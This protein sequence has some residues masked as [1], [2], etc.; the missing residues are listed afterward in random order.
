MK[1]VLRL[2]S[3]IP[4]LRGVDWGENIIEGARRELL[5]IMGDKWEQAEVK[6][7]F[8]TDIRVVD[9]NAAITQG[10]VSTR[11]VDRDGDVMVPSGAMLEDFTKSPITL[12]NH[13]FS[14]VL[15]VE[16][17]LVVDDVGLWSKTQ[18]AP[19]ETVADPYLLTIRNMIVKGIIRARSIA[20]IPIEVLTPMF[21]AQRFAD[22]VKELEGM[23]KQKLSGVF[24]VVNKWL[25]TEISFVPV[26]ANQEALHEA[27][28]KGWLT[29]KTVMKQLGMKFV[30]DGSP[31][32]PSKHIRKVAPQRIIKRVQLSTERNTQPTSSGDHDITSEVVREIRRLRGQL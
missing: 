27:V 24:A 32:R 18:L 1:Q 30:I 21:D 19:A 17:E 11:A 6:R 9:P 3:L 26:G 29:D 25:L 31:K 2:C 23:W 15:G 12:W 28:T 7:K 14:H 5:P 20:F 22:R 10:Y 13:S 16:K 4:R 8:M